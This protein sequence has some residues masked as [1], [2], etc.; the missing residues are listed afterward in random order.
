MACVDPS[1]MTCN[2][3]MKKILPLEDMDNLEGVD[4]I[5]E[6]PEDIM[7]TILFRLEM[8][9]AAKT[10][11]LSKRWRYI[12]TNWTDFDFDCLEIFPECKYNDVPKRIEAVKYIN[13]VNQVIRLHRGQS[14]NKF[15]VQFGFYERPVHHIDRWVKLALAKKVKNLELEKLDLPL[16]DCPC[17]TYT[18]KPS[19]F[20][21]GISFLTCLRLIGVDV[22][23]ELLEFFLTE[24]HHLE[25][26]VVDGSDTLVSLKVASFKLKQLSI[27]YC[28][29]L[30]KLEIDAVNLSYLDY[31]GKPIIEFKSLPLS[32]A[33]AAFDGECCRATTPICQQIACFA[34][35]LSKFSV[36]FMM[37][38]LP[39]VICNIPAKSLP[40]FSNLKFLV[41]TYWLDSIV[42]L[43]SII[44]L[45]G[46]CPV[47]CEFKLQVCWISA[48]MPEEA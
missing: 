42:D 5:S 21:S 27:R 19:L 45:L 37:Y 18:L 28:D 2:A 3:N 29:S 13:W 11:I 34:M 32:L 40:C 36:S 24:C 48:C 10:S 30:N 15:R 12:W 35:Q 44:R 6:L 9:E 38:L 23:G 7:L 39:G 46:A 47:L 4:R 43:P 31:V 20:E 17:D 25:Q 22:S 41:L 14:I 8:K 33:E 26:L 1:N 16:Y